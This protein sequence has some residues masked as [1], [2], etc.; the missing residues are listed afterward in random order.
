MLT[1]NDFENFEF[2]FQDG[3]DF[4]SS[5]VAFICG[6]TTKLGDK[7]IGIS[8]DNSSIYWYDVDQ[9]EIDEV[10]STINLG[11]SVGSLC[12]RI[13]KLGHVNHDT[14]NACIAGAIRKTVTPA[15]KETDTSIQGEYRALESAFL[16]FSGRSNTSSL[17]L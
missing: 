2:T 10:L 13:A 12:S 8:W 15:H 6:G 5:N 7:G 17:S 16:A 9:V 3:V 11:E 1:I 4:D 14:S